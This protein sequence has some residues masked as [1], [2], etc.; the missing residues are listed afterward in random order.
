MYIYTHTYKYNYQ[1]FQAIYATS[2]IKI[3]LI[4]QNNQIWENSFYTQTEESYK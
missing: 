3:N 4:Q 1:K 2:L